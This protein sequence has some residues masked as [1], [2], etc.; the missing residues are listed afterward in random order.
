M[1]V[2]VL[3]AADGNHLTFDPPSVSGS[4]HARC[5]QVGGDRTPLARTSASRPTTRSWSRNSWSGKNS[6][7]PAGARR[8]I[9]SEV[10]RHSD[11]TVSALV[12]LL[13]AD[14]LLLELRERRGPQKVSAIKID[15]TLIPAAEFVTIGST[16]FGVA[17]AHQ[18]GGG[19]H[20]MSG[21]HNFGIVVY[22]YGRYT[23]YMYPGGPQPGDDQDHPQVIKA[24]PVRDRR[25]SRRVARPSTEHPSG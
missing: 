11:R 24:C 16:G 17:A 18:V 25:L 4:R 12:H 9:P 10:A 19:A 23:S 2:R 5:R 14:H 21:D 13:R 6:K 3:S 8:A 20:T 1:Y 15:G 7:D 22:G